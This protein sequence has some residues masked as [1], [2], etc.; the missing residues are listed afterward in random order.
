M[1]FARRYW[2]T[3]PSIILLGVFM[4]GPILWAFY[5]STTNTAL[6]GTTAT[7]AEFVAF[8]NYRRLFTDKDFFPSVWLTVIFVFVSAIIA[9][10]ALGMIVAVLLSRA[11]RIVGQFVS[12][13]IIAAWVLPEMVAGFACYAFFSKDGTLNQIMEVL[14]LHGVEWLY[15]FPMFAVILANIWRG[16]AFSMMNYQAAIGEVDNSLIEAAV[17]DGASAW[18]AFIHVTIPVIRQTIMTNLMLITLQTMSAFTLIFVMTN[19]GPGSKSTTLP[20]FAY[21]AAFKFGDIGYGSAIAVVML[22]IGAIFGIV[23]VRALRDEKGVTNE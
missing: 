6:T 11:N 22:F 10:N 1:K 14:G 17:V 13:S 21:K 8:E 19:G 9:Q 5:G 23:Y 3:L 7:H 16:T 4:L 12:T 18:Q 15:V 20:I 2:T